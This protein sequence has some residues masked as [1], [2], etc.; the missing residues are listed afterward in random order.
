MTYRAHRQPPVT[1][2]LV[3]DDLADVGQ[4]EVRGR[5]NHLRLSAYVIRDGERRFVGEFNKLTKAMNA[6][7]Q[8]VVH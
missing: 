3:G 1:L 4:I 2:H 7:Q 6:I 8:A 5:S